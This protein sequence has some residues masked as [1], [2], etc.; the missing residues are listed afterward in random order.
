MTLSSVVLPEPERPTSATSSPGAI[1]KDTSRSAC[2]AAAPVPYV[3]L[4]CSTRTRAPCWRRR[5][6]AVRRE[7]GRHR[8]ASSSVGAAGAA[9]GAGRRGPP[10]CGVAE[11]RPRGRP[12]SRVGARPV[13]PHR[14]VRLL[15]R[16]PHP[17][18]EVQRL[19]VLARQ[20]H[21]AGP[22]EHRVLLGDHLGAVLAGVGA[23]HHLR[24]G[25]AVADGDG[26]L[27]V[28][29][30]AGV[31]R[32]DDDRGAQ[33]AVDGPQAL[34]D[35]VRGRG[36]ELAGRLVGEQHLRGV[37]QRD[38][39]R[40]A[41]LLAAGHLRG[42]P[43]G[44]VPDAEHVEQLGGPAVA[45]VA[46]HPGERQREGHVLGRSGTAPCC[47]RSAARRTRPSSAGTPP[48]ARRHRHEVPR[49]DADLAGGRDVE[50][51]QDRQQGR[52]ARPGRADDREQLAVLDEQVQPL[53]RLHLDA[54]GLVDAHQRVADDE[55]V[56]AEVPGPLPG[57]R[58]ERAERGSSTVCTAFISASCVV[59][60]SLSSFAHPEHL[61]QPVPA[62]D[63][64]LHDDRDDERAQHHDG[65]PDDRD[66]VTC[67][68]VAAGRAGEQ[69]EPER[70]REQPRD[71]DAD[72][73]P[74]STAATASGASSPN[75][76]ARAVRA[77]SPSVRSADSVRPRSRLV[78]TTVSTSASA[79]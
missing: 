62:P 67:S 24:A 6:V 53:Q 68:D 41:L 25:A 18:D 66:P 17:P 19:P 42:P 35:V 3:R 37:R 44:A 22:V 65:R 23:A 51:G 14:D 9:G 77:S 33:L 71:R 15:E 73:V 39:D 79:A 31:V 2:T 43:V 47:A 63:R 56:L 60:S 40:D 57:A 4:T 74:A 7:G 70:A 26:A 11:C 16:Q 10:P 49:P 30:D 52:L 72:A 75:V 27:H 61:A 29:A 64:R 76:I 58:L 46:A 54:L 69:V 21:P 36:V 12:G 13:G 5:G 20:L 55:R 8:A 34:Q 32:D 48:A 38:R 78:A 59:P 50:P 45:R 1:V 28:L